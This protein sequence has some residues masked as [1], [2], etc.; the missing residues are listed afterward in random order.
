MEEHFA[1]LKLLD[2][3]ND[4]KLTRAFSYS[5]LPSSQR[6]SLKQSYSGNPSGLVRQYSCEQIFDKTANTKQVK[7]SEVVRTVNNECRREWQTTVPYSDT[8]NTSNWQLGGSNSI[9]QASN[10]ISK[11]KSNEIEYMEIDHVDN[12]KESTF[13]SNCL[14]PITNIIDKTEHLFSTESNNSENIST[15]QQKI[16][17]EK[18][19]S[20]YE[21]L[22]KKFRP[23]VPKAKVPVKKGI[24][25]CYCNLLCLFLIPILVGVIA[26][27]LNPVTYTICSRDIF[28]SNATTQIQQK[29]YGQATAIS[30][31]AYALHQDVYNLKV[32]CLIGGTGVGKSYTIGIINKNFPYKQKIFV[33]DLLLN[34]NIDES[35]LN[36]FNS[37]ELLIIENL[38]LKNLDVFASILD[39]LSKNKDKCITV[40]AV[41]N[42]E[43]VDENL[44]RN[45]DLVKSENVITNAFVKEA[46]DMVIVPYIPLS[47]Q[48]L[49]MCIMDVTKNSNLKLTQSQIGEIKQSL[50]VS[51]SGCKGAYAKAQVIGRE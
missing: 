40:F 35:T 37:Y 44:N 6:I 41:F 47:E 49:E 2:S 42:V 17:K 33:Y 51:G 18:T 12:V 32:I 19:G 45:V 24:N 11:N 7:I 29:L 34:D 4:C 26:L 23:L 15:V 10:L 14:S 1:T 30:T 39:T 46:I 8:F 31:I 43:E 25:M 50:L 48:A 13:L 21:D 28:F 9:V 5:E 16:T 22:K 36:S 20:T 3:D 27:L 38:K